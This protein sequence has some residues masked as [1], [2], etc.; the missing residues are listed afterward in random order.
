MYVSESWGWH[1]EALVPRKS[2]GRTGEIETTG[3]ANYLYYKEG[4]GLALLPRDFGWGCCKACVVR[5]RNGERTNGR[6]A[7]VSFD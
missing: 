2:R 4:I 6:A 3:T 5:R 1:D 7:H